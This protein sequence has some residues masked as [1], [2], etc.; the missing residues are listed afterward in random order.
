M[1]DQNVSPE[2]LLDATVDDLADIPEF[3]L[4][5]PGVHLFVMNWDLAKKI[6]DKTMIQL[7][8]K[9]ISTVEKA[10]EKDPD[11]T[12]GQETNI[13]FDL[14]SEWGQGAFKKVMAGLAEKF[15]PMSNRAL[16]EASNGSEARGLFNHNYV[17]KTDKTYQTLESVKLD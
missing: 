13:L 9:G 5:P 10:D 17:K 8:C 3:S 12:P 15:G 11:I 4:Y 6:G 16:C 7:S 1:S 14:K 2:D